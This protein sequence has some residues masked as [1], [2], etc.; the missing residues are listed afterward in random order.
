MD[1]P[2]LTKN[3]LSSARAIAKG[4]G[5]RDVERLVRDYGGNAADWRKVASKP[6]PAESGRWIELHWYEHH[7]IGRF[8]IKEVPVRL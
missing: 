1:D 4:R 2:R 3:R 7:G 5:I 6:F 8:E